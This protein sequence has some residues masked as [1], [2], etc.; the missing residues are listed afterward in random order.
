MGK[1]KGVKKWKVT[2]YTLTNLDAVTLQRNAWGDQSY[3]RT[4][5]TTRKPCTGLD[6]IL[7]ELLAEYILEASLI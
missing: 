1:L 5:T 4:I 3:N 2:D 6:Y 7:I